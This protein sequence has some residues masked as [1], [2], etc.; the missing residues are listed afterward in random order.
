MKKPLL[1]I[2]LCASAMKLIAPAFAQSSAQTDEAEASDWLFPVQIDGA[3]G[4]VDRSGEVVIPARY[5]S[6]R[7]WKDGLIAVQ[8]DDY[9]TIILNRAGETIIPSKFRY[10]FD[11]QGREYT[12]A[13]IGKEEVIID[14]RGNI[15]LGPGFQT[16][17][18]FER[19]RAW[20]VGDGRSKGV[21]TLDCEWLLEPEFQRVS[22]VKANGLA[23]VTTKKARVGLVDREGQ[24]I[25]KPGKKFEDVFALSKDGLMPAKSG[26][27]WGVIDNSANWVL[28]PIDTSR[29]GGPSIYTEPTQLVI[30]IDGKRGVINLDGA[31]IIPVVHT[32]VFG[33][34]GIAFTAEKDGK[35]GAYDRT[36]NLI[37]PIEYD[38]LGPFSDDGTTRATKDGRSFWIDLTGKEVEKNTDLPGIER[39]QYFGSKGWA[40]A[41]RNGKWGAVNEER[42]WVL[43]PKYD[44]VSVCYDYPPSPPPPRVA[45]PYRPLPKGSLRKPREQDWCRVEG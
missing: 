15:V 29:F 4:V 36:G 42:E 32:N 30:E 20:I 25:A 2:A 14:R 28:R 41:K 18:T 24:W 35:F 26:G 12:Q 9:D 22:A 27:K 5:K 6:A 17:E 7:I 8:G 19:D 3:W 38:R 45:K 44:C 37:V 34:K 11:F 43:E 13:R 33:G 31:V 23:K 10:I 40:A 16:I 1:F 21:V 39:L